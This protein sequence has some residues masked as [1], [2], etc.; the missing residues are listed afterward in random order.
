MSKYSVSEVSRMSGVSVR[1]LHYYDEID[2]LKPLDRTGVGYRYY[3]DQE[4]LRLQQILFFRELDFPLKEISKCINAPE[5][6]VVQALEQHK[7]A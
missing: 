6:D 2:L 7:S 5:F 1:T 3:G 4:L